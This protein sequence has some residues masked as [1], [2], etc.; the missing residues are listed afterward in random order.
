MRR[1]EIGK[2]RDFFKVLA[3]TPSAQAATMVLQS[4]ESSGEFANEHPH[5]EQWLLVVSGTGR[6]RVGKRCVALRG[7]SLLL[8]E[9]NEPHQIINTGRKPLVTL[10]LYAP[11]AYTNDGELKTAR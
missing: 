9:K 11:P 10:N 5:S 8:I 7:N 1:I 2:H 3:S 6:A 4:G